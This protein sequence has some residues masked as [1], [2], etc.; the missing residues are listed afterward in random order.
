MIQPVAPRRSDSELVDAILAGSIES[1]HEFVTRYSGLVFSVVLRYV[2]SG[3]EDARRDVFVEILRDFHDE[4]LRGYDRRFALST[5]VVVVSR[6][7]CLDHLRRSNGRHQLPLGIR[8]L[9]E[10]DRQVYHLY[11]IQGLSYDAICDHVSTNG[12]RVP[13]ETVAGSMS[14]IDQVLDRSTKT[15][16]AYDL[17]ARS[18]GATSGRLLQYLDDLHVRAEIEAG[19]ESPDFELA[20]EETRAVLRRVESCLQQLSAED[21]RAV[22][23]RY[24]EGQPAEQIAKELGLGARRRAYTILD[25]AL[26]RIRRMLEAE[27]VRW[28]NQGTM[29]QSTRATKHS[30]SSRSPALKELG[31]MR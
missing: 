1:W 25:H 18:V 7:R 24:A 14:R 19:T 23:L 22:Q 30:R 27:E 31:P 10:F 9:S 4:K 8:S 13:V 21:R 12:T 28:N 16:L 20:Q 5:W 3:G 6:S 17:A 26:A 2:R 11:Y 15:R 29:D